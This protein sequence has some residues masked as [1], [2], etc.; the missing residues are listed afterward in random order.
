MHKNW[1]W[2]K[3]LSYFEKVVC[4]TNIMPQTTNWNRLYEL[5]L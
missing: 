3:L 4:V 2:E 1:I 5:A